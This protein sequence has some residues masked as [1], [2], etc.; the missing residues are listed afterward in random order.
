MAYMDANPSDVSRAWAVGAMAQFMGLDQEV[1][2]VL[3]Q[4]AAHNPHLL[5]EFNADLQ[6]I[7]PYSLPKN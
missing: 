7:T 1:G 3:R 5:D 2:Y 4:V 6:K